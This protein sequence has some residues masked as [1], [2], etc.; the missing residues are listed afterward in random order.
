VVEI[1]HFAHNTLFCSSQ[2]RIFLLLPGAL[3]GIEEN[4]I[5]PDPEKFG[6]VQRAK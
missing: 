3:F 5:L 1:L 4:G 2:G 6:A